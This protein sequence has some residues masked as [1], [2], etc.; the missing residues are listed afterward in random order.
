MPRT[1]TRL[2]ARCAVV[3]LLAITLLPAGSIG[4][5]FATTPRLG[6]GYP[7]V[8]QQGALANLAGSFAPA[9]GDVVG[10]M[11]F[12]GT[13]Q[14]GYFGPPPGI[15]SNVPFA[16]LGIGGSATATSSGVRLRMDGDTWATGTASVSP[17][18]LDDPLVVTGSDARDALGLGEIVLVTPLLI[19][20]ETLGPS[21]AEPA[22]FAT[23]TLRFVPEPGTTTLIGVGTLGLAWRS[24]ARSR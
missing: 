22:G 10:S 5:T 15:F 6:P 4:G 24:R 17:P 11:G 8:S 20:P 1:P 12:G 23:L 19:D 7:V 9:G 13:W 3:V 2:A 14:W 21:A 18:G 16:S